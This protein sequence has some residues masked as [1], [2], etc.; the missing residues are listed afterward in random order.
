MKMNFFETLFWKNLCCFF[1]CSLVFFCLSGNLDKN[2]VLKGKFYFFEK[3]KN[4]NSVTKLI[5]DN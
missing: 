5:F 3:K 2:V 4:F 1:L